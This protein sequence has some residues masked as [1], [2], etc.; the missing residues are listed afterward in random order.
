MI[1]IFR[2]SNCNGQ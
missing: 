2:S 1:W